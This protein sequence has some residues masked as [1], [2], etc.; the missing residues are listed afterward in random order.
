MKEGLD[1]GQA[2]K[3]AEKTFNYASECNEF[4]KRDSDG[5]P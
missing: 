3:L 1:Y 2:H 5:L 4:P